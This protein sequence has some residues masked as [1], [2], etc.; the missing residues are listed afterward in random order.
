MTYQNKVTSQGL[1]VWIIC[2]SFFLY[3]FFLRTIIGTFQHPIMYD[4]KLTTFKFS[5]LSSTSYQVIYALMQIPAGLIVSYY[6]LR[7]TIFVAV[8]LCSISALGFAS[9]LNFQTAIAFRLLAGFGSSFGFICLLVCV[10][11]WLPNNKSAFFIGCSQFIGTLGPMLAAG[12]I[13]ALA[14]NANLNWRLIFIIIGIVGA[15]LS[16]VVFCFVKNNTSNIGKYQI[17]NKPEGAKSSIKRLFVKTQPLLI[18]LFSAC[19]YF[20]IEYLSENEGK[21]FVEMKGFSPSFA[22]YMITLSWLGYA[23]GC[24]TIG[25]FSDKML[26]RKKMVMLTALSYIVGLLF[27]IYLASTPDLILGFF[28]MGVGASGQSIGFALMSEQ[29]KKS[30]RAIGLGLNN[31]LITSFSAINAPIIGSALDMLNTTNHSSNLED[32]QYIFS[33]LLLF[34]AICLIIS[35]FFIK[36]TFCKSRADWTLLS[37]SL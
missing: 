1:F 20:F 9:C 22:S 6:G 34:I 28:L 13:N 37:K 7:K 2:A 21:H 4:L 8:V 17:L 10:Y 29:F 16:I 35:I 27:I 11:D 3:E 24:A 25:Y 30:T 36:E 5:L 23:I 19:S 32:Y 14:E 18:G 12:P 31:A 15:L 26:N 33:L